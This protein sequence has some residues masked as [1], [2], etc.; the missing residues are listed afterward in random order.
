VY[1]SDFLAIEDLLF[2]IH[3]DAFPVGGME[4]NVRAFVK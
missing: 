3:V 4:L 1:N 2:R